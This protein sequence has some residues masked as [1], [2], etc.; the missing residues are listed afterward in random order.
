[1]IVL[2]IEQIVHMNE[3]TATNLG[4]FARHELDE[5]FFALFSLSMLS[6]RTTSA[7]D[8]SAFLPFL[9]SVCKHQRR[10]Q[11][12]IDGGGMKI[13]KKVKRRIGEGKWNC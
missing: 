6:A 4:N 11:V 13:S 3:K 12:D 5:F 1:M 7:R 2:H 10:D 9:L 8:A